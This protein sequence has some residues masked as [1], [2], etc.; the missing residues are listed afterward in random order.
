VN[1]LGAAA[2][3]SFRFS[4]T[5]ALT[6]PGHA[7]LVDAERRLAQELARSIAAALGEPSEPASTP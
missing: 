4:S 6:N 2:P 7:G 5:P 3:R 1:L